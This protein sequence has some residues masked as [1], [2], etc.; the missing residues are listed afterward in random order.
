MDFK[1]NEPLH[2]LAS[3]TDVVSKCFESVE[4]A[5]KTHPDRETLQDRQFKTIE[6]Y[7]D[8]KNPLFNANQIYFYVNPEVNHNSHIGRF[9]KTF[10]EYELVENVKVFIKYN[11]SDASYTKKQN[12][13]L[14]TKQGVLKAVFAKKKPTILH[15]LFKKFIVALLDSLNEKHQNTLRETL[16]GEVEKYKKYHT[17]A[18]ETIE[19]HERALFYAKALSTAFSDNSFAIRDTPYGEVPEELK[20]LREMFCGKIDV[21]VVDANFMNRVPKIRKKK[22]SNLLSDDDDEKFDPQ[23]VINTPKQMEEMKSRYNVQYDCDYKEITSLDKDKTESNDVMFF[24]VSK[25]KKKSNP[26]AKAHHHHVGTLDI[27]NST[28]YKNMWEVLN[29]VATPTH[30]SAIVCTYDDIL[31]A[32]DQGIYKMA[33]EKR[34]EIW[35]RL[36][37]IRCPIEF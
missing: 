30:T 22:S 20:F 29:K 6:I 36:E 14:L 37:K 9:Y 13:N 25:Y 31:D 17:E 11:T 5:L 18:Q 23:E 3:A 16:Q 19:R 32:R 2:P 15:K 35:A 7:G 24:Y 4:E 10:D 34:Q 26:V 33:R 28:H 8:P 21:Y 1:L 27:L 12:I